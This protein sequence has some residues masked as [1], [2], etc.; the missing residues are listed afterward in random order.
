MTLSTSTVRNTAESPPRMNRELFGLFGSKAELA[1]HCSLSE[2]DAV[3]A[4]SSVAV[5]IRDDTMDLPARSSVHEG[6]DGHCVILGEAWMDRSR[7]ESAAEQLYQRFV[8][9]GSEAFEGIYGSYLV[10]LEHDDDVWIVPDLIRS[11]ECFYTDDSGERVFGTDAARVARTIDRPTLNERAANELF[12]FGV[13]FGTGTLLAELHRQPFDRALDA[14]TSR[15]LERFVYRTASSDRDYA[16]DLA[17]R[18]EA[19]V[20]ERIDYPDPKGALTSAGYDSRFLLATIPDL[21]T[22]YTLGHPTTPEIE[23]ARDVATQYGHDHE[24][25]PVTP[26]YLDPSPSIVQY[27]N[28]IRESLH[29]HH[30]G[31]ESA[32]DVVTM[33]H[34]L[35]LDTVLRDFYLPGREIDLFGHPLPLPGLESDP[36]FYQ[37]YR[38]RLDVYRNGGQ[39]LGKADDLPESTIEEFGERTVSSAIERCRPRTDSVY[40]AMAMLGVKLTPALP[41]RTHLADNFVESL[42]ATDPRLVEWHLTTPP[43]HRNS[44]TFQRAIEHVDGEIFRHRPPDRPYT[45]YTLNQISGFLR[46]NVPGVRSPGTAWPDRKRIYND[47]DMDARLFPDSEWVHDHPPRVKL[48]INDAL[49]WLDLATDRTYTPDDILRRT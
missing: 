45:S 2:F 26:D 38:D 3:V 30:R 10:V 11:W 43:E 19:V 6:S 16:A 32:L 22:C 41:F 14:E 15:D 12:H 9:E 33:Y 17:E 4:G 5:G 28:G 7:P 13:V 49:T 29:I 44:R 35:L 37:F 42:F 48:R 39:L 27:T 40:N 18:L 21:D 47:N 8:T 31:N 25:L 46:R 34:G 20:G 1:S 23:T 36:D 24:R